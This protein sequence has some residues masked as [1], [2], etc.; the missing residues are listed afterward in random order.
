MKAEGIVIRPLETIEE[1][2]M[3]E[4]AQRVI[5]EMQGDA[6]VVPLHV[7]LTAQKNGGLVLGAFDGDKMVGYLFGFL[8][9]TPEGKDKHCSHMMGVVPKYRALGIGEALKRRQ[10]EFV[11]SQGLDL[12]TWTYD[13]LESR[14]ARLNITKLGGICRTYIRNLYGEIRDALNAGLPSDRFQVEWWVCSRRVTT[15]LAE[16]TPRPTLDEVLSQGAAIVN[17]VELD[18]AGLPATLSWAPH[19]DAMVLVEIPANFQQI[20]HAD[21]KLARDWRLLTRALFEEYFDD[22]YVVTEF[23]SEVR[24]GHRRSF[25]L[26]EHQPALEEGGRPGE[27]RA[28]DRAAIQ[29]GMDLYNSGQYWECH[30]ALEAV[31]LEAP[32]EDKPFLQGLIQASAAFHKYLVQKNAVGAI[33]LLSRA[34]DKL[35]RYSDD[36][37]GLDMG[38]F[39]AGLNTCWREIV[40]LGQRHIEEFDASLVPTL[41]WIDTSSAEPNSQP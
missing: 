15:R 4:D 26:L 41:R 28:E 14:N 39:K 13:P 24:D 25:Y 19:R 7:L 6:D 12:V 38:P 34:L 21:M 22:G 32:A 18:S 17:E 5:W 30:E 1:F 35:I 2:Q 20:K 31:W 23:I 29:Q 36:Y 10:R 3:A 16:E 8:G 27:L 37:M 40:D 11:L 33:K 9:R